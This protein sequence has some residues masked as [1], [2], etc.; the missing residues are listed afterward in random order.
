MKIKV[1][2]IVFYISNMVDLIKEMAFAR[3]MILVDY[4]TWTLYFG[5]VPVS[6]PQHST[7]VQSTD[8]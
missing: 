4:D 6:D 8:N 7:W 3:T 1:R 2:R 5:C